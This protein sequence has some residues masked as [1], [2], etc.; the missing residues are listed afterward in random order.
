MGLSRVIA[1]A[2]LALLVPGVIVGA[3]AGADAGFWTHSQIPLVFG[4]GFALA[5]G[6]L[7]V[8]LPVLDDRLD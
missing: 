2:A 7:F 3:Y 1:L 6:A 5:I 8:L 4:V